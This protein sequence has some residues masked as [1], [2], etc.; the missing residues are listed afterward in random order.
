MWIHLAKLYKRQDEDGS[1]LN[2]WVQRALYPEA[3][4]DDASHAANKVNGW[5]KQKRV[6]LDNEQRRLLVDPLINVL[7][8]R[9]QELSGKDFSRLMW[10]YQNTGQGTLARETAERRLERNPSDNAC[11]KFLQ[12]DQGA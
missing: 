4:T 7:E 12:R 5:L 11:Q 10:L 8:K 3:S 9:S 2:A 1:A 6:V